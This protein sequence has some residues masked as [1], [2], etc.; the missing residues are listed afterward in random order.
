MATWDFNDEQAN[1]L[2]VLDMAETSGPQRVKRGEQ[3][4]YV[5][6]EEDW[7][8]ATGEVGENVVPIRK[9]G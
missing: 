6:L 7:L 9:T 2:D 5:L 1:L 3:R 8:A 4:F